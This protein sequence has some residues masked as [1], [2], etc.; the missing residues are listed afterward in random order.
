MKTFRSRGFTLFE[1]L[2]TIL[3]IGGSLLGVASLFSRGMGMV[4]EL[5]EQ[6]VAAYALQEEMELIRRTGFGAI[7]T[8]AFTPDPARFSCLNNSTGTRVVDYPLPNTTTNY[9]LFKRVTLTL[10]WN[11]SGGR[12]VTKQLVTYITSGGISG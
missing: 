1:I 10:R 9:T 8:S 12:Q 5:R 3:L 6:S 7:V 4:S 11:S 2:L